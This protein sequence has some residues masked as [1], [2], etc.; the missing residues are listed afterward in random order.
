MKE[1]INVKFVKEKETK[2]TVRFSE[3]TGP[4]GYNRVGTIY[5]PRATLAMAGINVENG[6]MLSIVPIERNDER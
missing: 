2:N 3:V 4:D 5:I 6:F 1:K